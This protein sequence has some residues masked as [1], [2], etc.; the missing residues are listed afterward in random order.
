MDSQFRDIKTNARLKSKQLWYGWRGQLLEGVKAG[1]LR[2][3][4]DFTADDE[5][6]SKQESILDRVLPPLLST[7]EGLQAELQV[8]QER[9]NELASSDQ[10]A[11]KD[12]RDRLVATG[13]EIAAKKALL[14]SLQKEVEAQSTDIET[15][16]ERKLECTE[17]IKMAERVR[18]ECRGWSLSDVNSLKAKITALEARYGWRIIHA[19]AQPQTLTFVYRNDL[20]LFLHPSAFSSGAPNAPIS[21]RYIGADDDVP[22]PR[23]LTTSKRFFLQ[24]LR[25]HI[26]CIPQGST[27]LAGLLSL[28]G[29]GWDAAL[30]VAE[31]VRQLELSYMVDEAIFADDKLSVTAAMLLPCL[32]TKTL[33]RFEITAAPDDRDVRVDVDVRVKNVYGERY[34]EAKMAKSL[35]ERVGDGLQTRLEMGLWAMAVDEMKTKLVRRGR[36]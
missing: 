3:Q 30:A 4:A 7:H 18:E 13:N 16:K 25:A 33:I 12:A 24:L 10:E 34:D 8:L 5:L 36:K 23:P 9:A 29:H 22:R 17:E 1:L 21:L 32:R 11:L 15:L 35:K 20:Q 6:L 14:V 28:I 31:G 2:H 19:G 27:P 26:Q